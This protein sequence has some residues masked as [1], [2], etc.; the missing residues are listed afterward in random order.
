M[1][2]VGPNLPLRDFGV[3]KTGA[4]SSGVGTN[5]W[6]K[7]L[8]AVIVPAGTNPAD[9][10][11]DEA[12]PGGVSPNSPFI[13]GVKEAIFTSSLLVSEGRVNNF[14]DALTQNDLSDDL[15][16]VPGPLPI[17]GAGVAFGFSRK[18]RRRIG[19]TA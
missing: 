15:S 16:Q 3:M 4:T 1:K 12:S 19:V 5:T 14:T 6:V 10:S 18:L 17:L 9:V 13:A 8:S 7:T 2:I 11:S